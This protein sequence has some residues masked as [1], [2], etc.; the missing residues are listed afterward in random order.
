MTPNS[1]NTEL[2]VTT[3]LGVVIHGVTI[4]RLLLGTIP[5]GDT[6]GFSGNGGNITING[7]TGSINDAFMV[8]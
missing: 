3:F 7:E 6:L 2:D 1:G 8:K 4:P 5:G